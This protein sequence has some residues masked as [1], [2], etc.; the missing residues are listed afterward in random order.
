MCNDG[1]DDGWR[2]D[3]GHGPVVAPCH[4]WR[5]CSALLHYSNT[6]FSA[7]GHRPGTFFNTGPNFLCRVSD[8]HRIGT[9]YWR[10]GLRRNRPARAGGQNATQDRTSLRFTDHQWFRSRRANLYRGGTIV[11]Y[12]EDPP[13]DALVIL[14]Y[15]PALPCSARR[16]PRGGRFRQGRV[17][18]VRA[19]GADPAQRAGA[20]AAAAAHARN[21]LASSCC[22]GHTGLWTSTW[23]RHGPSSI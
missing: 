13:V 6:C 12:Y 16:R 14:Q 8:V 9:N 19:R 5:S 18:R 3:V 22:L 20:R 1:S 23:P 2:D 15:G 4:L 7:E 21:P 17:H 11:I 10:P